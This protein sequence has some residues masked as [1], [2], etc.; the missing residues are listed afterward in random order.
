M[1]INGF[2]IDQFNQ[3]G[4]KEGAKT[5][6]CPF[7]S[8]YRKKKDEKCALLDWKTGLGTCQHCGEVFQLHT[9][10]K[11]K[12][13][14]IRYVRPEK[15]NTTQ[16]GE[17]AVAYF[18][19]RK[20]SQATIK[21]MRLSEGDEVMPTKAGSWEK[22]N[23]IQFNYFLDGEL[24]NVKYR[25]G[26]KQFKMFKDAERIFYNIDSIRLSTDVCIVEGE[27]DALSYIEAGFM[28]TVSVP[29]GSTL[30][31]VNLE[32]LDEYLPY[33]DNKERIYLA[34]DNDEAGQNVQAEFVRRLGAERC[35][36]VD[37][38]DCKDA[39]EYLIKYGKDALMQTLTDSAPVPLEGV[40]G[41][42]DFREAFET[43]VKEGMPK[44]FMTGLPNFDKIFSTFTKQFIVVT[45]IPSSGKS[46]FVDEMVLGYA[47]KYDW[48]IAMASKENKPNELHAGK[49]MAKLT[50]HWMSNAEYLKSDW[51]EKSLLWMNDHFKFVDF[52]KNYSIDAVLELGDQMVKRYGIKC[53]V[54][55]PFNKTPLRDQKQRN[56]NEYTSEY[57]L[58]IDEW[59]AKND[60]LV[61]LVAHPTKSQKENGKTIGPSS[62]YDVAGGHEFFDMTPNG[63]LV[64]RDFDNDVVEVKVLKLKFSQQGE[65]GAKVFFKWHTRSGRY[66]PVERDNSG[67]FANPNV[68][69]TNYFTG[70]D[71]RITE[72]D[73]VLGYALPPMK[74]N[75]EF[76]IVKQEELP[77]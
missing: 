41:I 62:L 23:T 27:F 22:R 15:I 46:E 17:R 42:L 36:L 24:V 73:S 66:F 13:R 29:N 19:S 59:C 45:G 61:I 37:F 68:D 4:L 67:E 25:T 50:G 16:L 21:M 48:K 32:F 6:T 71:T 12:E 10:K 76:E 47:K 2:E 18:E 34:L 57:L 11:Q 30:G 38:K 3:Y 35:Y 64:N 65:N 1:Q 53:L 40:S 5:S 70:T 63:I 75:T 52:S 60:C 28:Q 20:I 74:P 77:F 51:Y 72:T 14:S 44:G 58:K 54:V 55:D 43:Y 33:F 7:C 9:F 39:N 69:N 26:D 49:I 8:A 31:N 56:I